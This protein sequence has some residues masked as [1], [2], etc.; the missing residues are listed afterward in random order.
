M[1]PTILIP[2]GPVGSNYYY[3]WEDGMLNPIFYLESVIRRHHYFLSPSP[4][5]PESE[6]SP[7]FYQVSS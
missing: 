3:L 7:S 1:R 2:Y 6:P 4:L 5:S